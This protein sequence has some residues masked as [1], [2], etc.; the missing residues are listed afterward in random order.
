MGSEQC[1]YVGTYGNLATYSHSPY[2]M[3]RNEGSY[4]AW[5][6]VGLH[7]G[8]DLLKTNDIVSIFVV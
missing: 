5:P 8:L 4:H 3:I 6:G 1:E 2:V 7:V